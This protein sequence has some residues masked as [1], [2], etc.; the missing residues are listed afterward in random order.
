MVEGNRIRVLP[1]A[2]PD[3]MARSAGCK[4]G[5]LRWNHRAVYHTGGSA[6]R[7][8]TGEPP[9]QRARPAPHTSPGSRA[10]A[11]IVTAEIQPNGEADP[12]A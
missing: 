12:N 2:G 10:E 8:I 1:N 3:V 9:A 11:G 6:L 7:Q 5:D 4:V